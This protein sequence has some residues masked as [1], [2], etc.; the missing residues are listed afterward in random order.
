MITW[1]KSKVDK[2]LYYKVFIDGE[3]H[4][5]IRG[6]RNLRYFLTAMAQEKK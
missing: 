1:E 5:E 6:Y 3:F 2:L 4:R